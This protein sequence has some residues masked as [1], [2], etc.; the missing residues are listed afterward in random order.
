MMLRAIDLCGGAGGWAIAARG[1]PIRITH[2]VDWWLPAVRTYKLN[3]PDTLVCR[4]DCRAMPIEPVGFDVVLG[5]IPC[6]WLTHLRSRGLGNP[7]RPDEIER[8]R[9]LLDAVLSWREKA[10]PR[11]WCLEDVVQLKRELPIFTPSQTID[12]RFFSGQRRKRLYV[13]WFPAPRRN[14]RAEDLAD[15]YMRP[16]PYRVHHDTLR[17]VPARRRTWGERDHAF[18]P[19]DREHKWPTVMSLGSRHD[20]KMAVVDERLPGGKR[21]VEWQE[22]ARA[23]GFPDDYV[24]VGNQTETNQMIANAIQI[25]TGRAILEAICRKAGQEG[26][27][28][29]IG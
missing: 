11:W 2:A 15:T 22:A 3:H 28:R 9:E 20:K 5:G 14:G 21:A 19:V 17:R 23:Q 7:P 18:Y 29:E 24:F 6:Q 12:A 27:A 26:G 25:D 10:K 1:L 8:E 16:G 13:G 4:G